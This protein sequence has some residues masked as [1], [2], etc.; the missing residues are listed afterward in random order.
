MQLPEP[1]ETPFENVELFTVPFA[2]LAR[3]RKMAP[4]PKEVEVKKLQFCIDKVKESSEWGIEEE[5]EEKEIGG[6]ERKGEV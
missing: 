3:P 1:S 4:V 6:K 2:P 5:M